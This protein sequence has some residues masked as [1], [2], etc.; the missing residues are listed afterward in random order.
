M[1]SANINL[2][3]RC[4]PCTAYNLKYCYCYTCTITLKSKYIHLLFAKNGSKHKSKWRTTNY[5]WTIMKRT[6]NR[7][8]LWVISANLLSTIDSPRIQWVLRPWCCSLPA[9][10]PMLRSAVHTVV[11]GCG[12]HTRGQRNRDSVLIADYDLSARTDVV[13]G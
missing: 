12:G 9:A 6:I 1:H 5:I 4:V 7:C 11:G 2:S 13:N 8:I 3:F 10:A